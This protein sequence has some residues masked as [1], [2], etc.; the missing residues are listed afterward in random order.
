MIILFYLPS[1]PK[2]P[3]GKVL[4]E[5]CTHFCTVCGSTTS[6]V[7]FLGLFG[8]RLCHNPNCPNSKPKFK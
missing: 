7:G 8:E 5:G 2:P 1:P 6:R 3:L 4:K